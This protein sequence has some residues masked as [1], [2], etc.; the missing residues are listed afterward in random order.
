MPM[1]EENKKK[2][3]KKSELE[4]VLNKYNFNNVECIVELDAN[5]LSCVL[6]NIRKCERPDAYSVVGDTAYIIE[7]FEFDSYRNNKKGSQSKV[8]LA[9]KI[10]KAN[11]ESIDLQWHITGEIERISS[12]KNYVD[13]FIKHLNYHYNQIDKYKNH[14]SNLHPN[15]KNYKIWFFCED[16]DSIAPMIN[17]S[18]IAC[19]VHPLNFKRVVD[20]LREKKELDGIIIGASFGD[21]TNHTLFINKKYFDKTDIFSEDN[22]I[23]CTNCHYIIS[24]FKM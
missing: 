10:N 15:I 16:E 3:H 8:E 6:K 4:K 19:C 9:A 24:Q 21:N 23:T 17:N 2:E 5:K 14:I 7:H 20:C 18:Q 11:N 22:N 12:F 1:E 13:N